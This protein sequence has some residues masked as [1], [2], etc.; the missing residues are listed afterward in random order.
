MVGMVGSAE[1]ISLNPSYFSYRCYS[2]VGMVGGEQKISLGNGCTRV[3]TVMHEMMHALG[4][5]HE[6]SRSDRDKHIIIY[7]QNINP[8]KWNGL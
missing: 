7:T 6:Q 3:G 1:K 2:M 8:S 5:W 4:F